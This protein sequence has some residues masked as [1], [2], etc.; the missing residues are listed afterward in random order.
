MTWRDRRQIAPIKC[1]PELGASKVQSSGYRERL[2][3]T[4]TTR[5]TGGSR[6][7]DIAS[8]PPHSR[9]GIAFKDPSSINDNGHMPANEFPSN[10]VSATLFHCTD[11]NSTRGTGV[12]Q[13][14]VL[15]H[16]DRRL[17]QAYRLR[18]V[19]RQQLAR[20]GLRPVALFCARPKRSL[21][22]LRRAGDT[23]RAE[24]EA[25]GPKNLAQEIRCFAFGAKFLVRGAG[26]ADAAQA[27]AYQDFTPGC[28]RTAS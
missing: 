19:D 18:P 17:R 22:P 8:P 26:P 23:L 5:S 21:T 13:L 24:F 20:G 25:P 27:F 28:S 4:R 10:R 16:R 3:R 15:D 11:A 14:P 2:R 12:Q 6:Q 1:R 9:A 7:A